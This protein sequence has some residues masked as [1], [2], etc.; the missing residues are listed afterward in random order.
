MAVEVIMPKMG[1]SIVEGTIVEWKKNIGDKIVLI[2][3]NIGG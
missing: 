1:E 2:I 3:C